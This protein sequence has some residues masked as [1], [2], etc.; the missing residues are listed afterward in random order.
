[1]T[2]ADRVP[3]DLVSAAAQWL[4]TTPQALRPRPI[5]PALRERFG[6]TTVEACAAVREANLRHTRAT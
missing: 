3:S 2:G 1:M 4:A 5:V 6:L